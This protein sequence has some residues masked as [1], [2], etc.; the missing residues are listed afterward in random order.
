MTQRF[1]K[2]RARDRW[3]VIVTDDEP[4]GFSTRMFPTENNFCFFFFNT[5]I[6]S[7]DCYVKITREG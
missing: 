4:E 7:Q 6:P 5:T 2:A 1:H 3:L